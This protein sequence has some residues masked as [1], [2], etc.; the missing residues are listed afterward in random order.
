MVLT[1]SIFFYSNGACLTRS[2][3]VSYKGCRRVCL[4]V[5]GVIYLS[6]GPSIKICCN[7]RQSLFIHL[8]RFSVNVKTSICQEVFHTF[9]LVIANKKHFNNSF[10]SP[11]S[12]RRLALLFVGVGVRIRSSIFPHKNGVGFFYRRS[13][14][15]SSHYHSLI[16][17]DQFL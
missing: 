7:T 15:N 17:H 5:E 13:T 11:F 2:G 16:F 4:F 8:Y 6:V 12:D 9:N 10:F 14:S 1:D 3:G